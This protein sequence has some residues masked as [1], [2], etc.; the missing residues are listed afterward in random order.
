MG[1][2]LGTSSIPPVDPRIG[3]VYSERYE[4][5]RKSGEG[6]MGDVYE[7]RHLL[8][9]KR[10]ALKL[11]HLSYASRPE[12]LKRFQREAQ[13]ASRIAHPHIVE[14][15]DLGR[16]P[17]GC[18]FMVLEYL[19]GR[20]LG[21]ELA[22]GGPMSLG[23]IARIAHQ[24]ASALAAAHEK[25]IV[26][27]DLKPENVFLCVDRETP[28]F[29]K[30]L[31]FGISKF[32]GDLSG[33]FPVTVT[34]ATL[35]TPYYMAPEHIK[36]S[37]DVDARADIWALGVMIYRALAGVYPF[38]A[39][40]YPLLFVKICTE[41]PPPITAFRPDVPAEF[42]AIL[43]RMLEKD[44]NRRFASCHEVV[45]ALAPF[46]TFDTPPRLRAESEVRA[47]PSLR[48]G[49]LVHR[50]YGT[51][52]ETQAAPIAGLA[53]SGPSSDARALV[54][55]GLD[56][57]G[58]KVPPSAR[59]PRESAA[60]IEGAPE[61]D[62]SRA[63]PLSLPPAPGE[64]FAPRGSWLAEDSLRP[65]PRVELATRPEPVKPPAPRMRPAPDGS[66]VVQTSA[67]G[68]SGDLVV[69]LAIRSLGLLGLAIGFGLGVRGMHGGTSVLLGAAG[70]AQIARDASA[71]AFGLLGAWTLAGSARR[72]SGAELRSTVLYV[73]VGAVLLVVLVQFL[74]SGRLPGIDP[75][76]PAP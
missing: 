27:R 69:D 63:A 22:V 25:G 74:V 29:V 48:P 39:D 4:L 8:I 50:G 23:R 38:D 10:V 3:Q 46:R 12:M 54:A 32:Q 61:H 42:A 49:G 47:A 19:E 66:R 6:G 7:A 31:D 57:T 52:L 53:P 40:S 65:A 35:G 34:G 30:V 68:A 64:A 73:I 72:A 17:D 18:P 58:T 70:P 51:M 13:A 33:A 60:G 15:S 5:L 44:A 71:V 76:V 67:G 1:Q 24:V 43:V 2:L 14:A 62:P 21:K 26:H 28:D 16:T 36:A 41:E 55:A 9:D 75:I 37:R 11:L 56:L 59:L 45:T 20:D